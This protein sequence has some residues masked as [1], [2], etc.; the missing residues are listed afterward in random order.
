MAINNFR[1]E[2]VAVNGNGQSAAGYVNWVADNLRRNARG[3]SAIN[4]ELNTTG[5]QLSYHL[6]GYSTKDFLTVLCEQSSPDATI[7]GIVVPDDSYDIFLHKSQPIGSIKYSAVI[8]RK[9]NLGFAVSG[10]NTSDPYFTIV[11]SEISNNNYVIAVNDAR[12]I[13]YR[14]YVPLKTRVPY[15]YEFTNTQQVVDFLVSYQ[16]YLQSQGVVFDGTSGNLKESLDFVLSAKEFLTWYLQDWAEGNVIV[17]SPIADTL[18]IKLAHGTT[19]QLRNS[20]RTSC[21]LDQNFNLVP[22]NQIDINRY[23]TTTVIF[24]KTTATIGLVALDIVE[25]E[26]AVVFDNQ[27]PFKDIIYQPE[28]GN[29]QSRVKLLG[30]KTDGWAGTLDAPG[31]IINTNNVTEWQTDT[32]Y[33]AGDIVKYKLFYYVA[34][35]SVLSSGFNTSIWQQV[36]YNQVNQT[37]LPNLTMLSTMSR[38]Y[39]DVDV[40]N[41]DD[42]IDKHAKG[43]LGFRARNYFNDLGVDRVTQTKFYQAFIRGK[44][45]R[46]ALLILKNVSFGKLFNIVEFYEDWAFRVGEYGGT[47]INQFIEVNLNENY[48]TINPG[49]GELV[50]FPS[51]ASQAQ[52]ITAANLYKKPLNYTTDLFLKTSKI[53]NESYIASAGYVDESDIDIT[54][55]DIQD[56][57]SI[58]TALNA[59][60]A[61]A[62]IWC[63]LDY[64]RDW[65]VY[66]ISETG[67]GI[68]LISNVL[69]NNIEIEFI[70]VHYLNEGDVVVIKNFSQLFDGFYRVK[71]APT[72]D[73]I[74]V[75]TTADLTG[76]T[77]ATGSCMFFKL[78]S[79]RF[80]NIEN[81]VTFTPKNNWREKE[82][83]WIDNYD[84][85]FSWAVLEKN[86]PWDSVSNSLTANSYV[87]VYNTGVTKFGTA[88]AADVN[89][90]NY[91]ITSSDGNKVFLYKKINGVYSVANTVV[92]SYAGVATFGASLDYAN[93]KLVV[94][95]PTSNRFGSVSIYNKNS[96]DQLIADQYFAPTTVRGAL[97]GYAVKI[98]A[99]YLLVGAPGIN[100]VYVYKR[101]A[102]GSFAFLQQITNSSIN[103]IY[104]RAGHSIDMT[105][106]EDKIYIGAPYAEVNRTYHAGRVLV[107]TLYNGLF[108]FA[109]KI[110][111]KI[112]IKNAE[113]GSSI[114]VCSRDCSLFVG[115]PG[116]SFTSAYRTGQVY[117]FTNLGRLIG[118]VVSREFTGAVGV[119]NSLIINGVEV[120]INGSIQQVGLSI[121]LAGILNVYAAVDKNIL[122]I[123]SKS[124]IDA[125]KL[126]IL[127]GKGTAYVDL[128]LVVVQETQILP[129]PISRN[130]SKFGNELD[131]SADNSQL[132][133]SSPLA[134]TILHIE[135]DGGLCIFDDDSTVF[136]D[137]E[138]SS[139]SVSVFQYIKP[140]KLTE[141]NLG[142]YIFGQQ[143]E[144]IVISAA[145]QFGCSLAVS[146]DTVFVGASADDPVVDGKTWTAAGTVQI[147][148][149]LSNQTLWNPIKTAQ[150]LIDIDIINQAFIYNKQNNNIVTFLDIVDP[151]KG[152]ILGLARQ[153]IDYITDQDPAVYDRS[154]GASAVD[155]SRIDEGAYWADNNV[156]KYWL[157]TNS[158][159][160]VDYEQ[161]TLEYR[162]ANWSRVFPGSDVKVY[163]W[164]SSDVIPSEYSTNYIGTPR[165]AN[166]E[167]YVLSETVD[168]NTGA[169]IKTYYYWVRGL[170]T[171]P[172][173]KGLST[174]TVESYIANPKSS[175]LPYLV[176][177]SPTAFGVY[178]IAESVDADNTVLHIDYDVQNNDNI[179]HSEYELVQEDL[180][181]SAP[182]A[183]IIKKFIDSLVGKNLLNQPVPDPTLIPSERYGL[184]IR[185]RQT[186][187]VDRIAAL[188][189]FVDST[190]RIFKT[191]FIA[192]K[193]AGVDGFTNANTLW[194]YVPWVAEGYNISAKPEYV[195]DRFHDLQRRTYL[196]GTVIKIKNNGQGYYSVI[197]ITADGYDLLVQ[198]H[199][200]I[201]L[202]PSIYAA[203]AAAPLVRKLIESMFYE[204]FVADLSIYNNRLFFVLVRY[205]LGEQKYIDWAFKTSFITVEHTAVKFEQ[206][207]N[208]QPDNQKY[209][210]D[211]LYEA[212][213]YHTKIREYKPAYT[214]ITD[215]GIGIT[216]FD[217]PAYYDTKLNRFRSPSGEQSGDTLLLNSRDEYYAWNNSYKF[218][219][220]SVTVVNGG[221]GYAT[222][223]EIKFIGG[224]GSGATARAT[225]SG[226][227]ITKITIINSGDNYLS[228]PGVIINGSG[229]GAVLKAR[230]KN[231][232][233]RQIS[234]VIKYDRIAYA[235][236]AL[237]GYDTAN[238][239][240][241]SYDNHNAELDN[242]NALDRVRDQYQHTAGA[243]GE[244][245]SLVFDGID[246]PGYV[247]KGAPNLS[248]V[249]GFDIPDWDSDGFDLGARLTA[250]GEFDMHI[251][252]VYSDLALGTRAEDI[253]WQGGQYVDPYHSHAPQEL[254][255]G[256]MFDTLDLKVVHLSQNKGGR[257]GSGIPINL[258]S[259][260]G[261]GQIT[262]FS[263][264]YVNTTT[265]DIILVYSQTTGK[266][267]DQTDYVIDYY[268]RTITF[269][270]APTN[271]EIIYLYIT[272]N[273]GTGQIF[274]K[275]FIAR[276]SYEAYFLPVIDSQAK[277]VLAL[278]DGVKTATTKVAVDGGI[279]LQLVSPVTAGAKVHFEVFNSSLSYP[280]SELRVETKTVLAGTRTYT[281][282]N[283][284]ETT[285]PRE[286]QC[287]VTINGLRLT[288]PSYTYY[289]GDGTTT[290]FA[291]NNT[292]KIPANA[293]TVKVYLDGIQCTPGVQYSTSIVGNVY[294]V[295]FVIAPPKE[296][297]IDIGNLTRAEFV[298][299][300]GTTLVI[301][302]RV[303]LTAGDELNVISFTDSEPLKIRTEVF[304]G[305]TLFSKP[306]LIG[307]D[308]L[309]L[310]DWN[311]DSNKTQD[312][313]MPYY[314]LSRPVTDTVRL[315]V[316]VDGVRIFPNRDY[317]MYDNVTL[318]ILNT[319]AISSNSPVVVSSFTETIAARP[320]SFRIFKNMINEY[321]YYRMATVNSTYLI[322]DL[323]ITD[324]EIYVVDASVLDDPS[325]SEA[326]PGVIFIN[327]ERITYYEKD[328]TTN[329]LGNI[330]RSTGGTGAPEI[331]ELGRQ[332]IGAS[333]SALIKNA[334]NQIWY[335]FTAGTDTGFDATPWENLYFDPSLGTLKLNQTGLENQTSAPAKFLKEREGLFLDR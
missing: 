40:E 257:E 82:N 329:I 68:K 100:T 173:L 222:A 213:P 296:S 147:F 70:D 81:S 298:I 159:R 162:T 195:V 231:S 211:Y 261:T 52:Q 101:N 233:V 273:I 194:K 221:Q 164:I 176:M 334:H 166:N 134:T 264:N 326:I 209:L 6:G 322:Q 331:H 149:N 258:Y 130:L 54:V 252:S 271:G 37:L 292:L 238:Y 158:V 317:I 110:E 178:N 179:I 186:L 148:K 242:K 171:V 45:A 104:D 46:D 215:A 10:Y 18:K 210:L 118:T 76:F 39:Y 90:S 24:C 120:A 19:D 320:M 279:E 203:N 310:D 140:L 154:T 260:S 253:A 136:V 183:R 108:Q 199:A 122:T 165:Y 275:S 220:G 75:E 127:P 5:V 263:F 245:Y 266:L 288:P 27:T 205:V 315:W 174:A 256:M 224:G 267:I 59:V 3:V 124:I 152:R 153:D 125:D 23:D 228:S 313:Y 323:Y 175:G 150:P 8:V 95:D 35:E 333:S 115:A 63:A 198:D 137:E 230:L 297:E 285:G 196:L 131:L 229:T 284:V 217:L 289:Y 225:V 55:F 167:S 30:T 309:P 56:A 259:F 132:F 272:D 2:N 29:R 116:V 14:D 190:N 138:V 73:S 241:D 204:L 206:F 268:N 177:Y 156:G 163:Q 103:G 53:Y 151:L 212:K 128:G 318:E 281:L 328:D 78:V 16:R 142:S 293:V 31:F 123:T 255:P 79:L 28:L 246:Y 135:F 287:I 291:V 1:K 207:P 280:T 111:T 98:T 57:N 321:S 189:N 92:A 324:T 214:G 60:H 72:I 91:F 335:D 314:T 20:I 105:S 244:D 188:K 219:V 4:R 17:L 11:E 51:L 97:Y 86:S 319:V 133:V 300:S 113:F 67:L 13:V 170:D 117:R 129:N 286:G 303:A 197:K 36:D 283:P 119:N 254:L 74:V 265:F 327:G 218:A 274:D 106:A 249:S 141:K 325:P 216:D 200:T 146:G 87:P 114:K 191:M 121:Q 227:A 181:S 84:G 304:V 88:V 237:D 187:F 247:L 311:W 126:S 43:L 236:T 299:D 85:E 7:N 50:D 93:S 69:D 89:D 143:L 47:D 48:F 161:Q 33:L 234:T 157:D 239:D 94:G 193:I 112:T 38:D 26:H 77:S 235:P 172:A 21:V 155:V 139:G 269:D 44:G 226:G 185:P 232:T 312:S 330:R 66:R 250:T 80:D 169:T 302:N 294:Y 107:Y 223:P 201:E 160:F 262:T 208:Y 99:N 251:S 301:D 144:S 64:N 277:Y 290:R 109:E 65:N 25:Y 168:K 145:D 243:P 61:G 316:T 192:D 308:S 12:A 282:D 332:V 42:E 49:L 295:D 83:I 240:T 9:T 276:G 182:P 58:S 248:R 270:T 278:V 34:L 62:V 22:A 41:L 32:L 305:N 180:D 102:A 306:L 71:S 202:L 15:G 307:F 96:A 184:A